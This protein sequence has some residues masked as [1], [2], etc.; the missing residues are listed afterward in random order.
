MPRAAKPPRLHLRS[1]PDRGSY[2][3]ILD[4]GREF[5]TGCREAD[6]E[7]ADRKFAQ[8]LTEKYEPPRTGGRIAD[9]LIADVI[10]LYLREQGP[11]TADGGAWVGHMSTRILDWWCAKAPTLSQVNKSNCGKYV[12][13]RTAQGVSDQTARH[14]LK[15]LRAAINHYHASEYGP[16][17]SVPVV[18]LPP[19]KPARQDYWLTR[20]MVADRIRAAR[21]LKLTKHVIRMLLIGVYTGT[22]PGA[23]LNLGWLP[24]PT[25]G[26]FDLD[27][28]TLHRAGAKSRRSRKAQPPARIHARLLPWLKRWR[29]ADLEKGIT[30]VVHYYG[31]PVKKLRRSWSSVAIEAGHARWDDAAKRWIVKDGPHICRHTAATWLMQSGVDQYEAAGYLGMSPET[32]WETYGHH[33][34]HFQDNAARASGKR[35]ARQG[36]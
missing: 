35:V 11:L 12:E 1:R 23:T 22:R 26:W 8:Y 6:R 17:Q 13:W 18:T 36:N 34:P 33:S 7:G 15:T 10:Q 25:G 27:S 19:G 30:R 29:E 21:R 9:T 5:G 16:L 4:S 14:E 3:V 24:S 31:R 20:N 2:W 28:L 32:L